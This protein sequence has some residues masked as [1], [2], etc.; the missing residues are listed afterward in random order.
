MDHFGCIKVYDRVRASRVSPLMK[1]F[2]P[3]DLPHVLTQEED[4][5]SK[6][7]ELKM[8]D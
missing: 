3:L 2:S 6:V 8:T 5:L 4:V 1:D 7:L